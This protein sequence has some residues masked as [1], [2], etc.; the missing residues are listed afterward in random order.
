MRKTKIIG[1]RG[2]AGTHPENTM[3]SFKEAERVGAYGIELDVHLSKDHVL[4]VIHDDKVDRTTNGSGW[5]KDL[6]ASELKEL[7]ASYKFG[8][9]Y[10]FCGIPTLEEVFEWA[11]SNELVINVELKNSLIDYPDIEQKT[12]NFI[13]RYQLKQRVFLSSFNHE[14]MVKANM[15][16]PSIEAAILYME[17]IYEPW[18]YAKKLGLRSIHPYHRTVREDIVKECHQH[19]VSVRPFTI[20]DEAGMKKMISYSCDAIITDYPE[21]ALK[22]KKR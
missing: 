7:D 3:I 16:D 10:G 9:K 21:K 6:K 15:I 13:N 18:E 20:N 2:A 8:D 11:L 4:M 12:I 19:N 14:S 17:K 1:H 22:L 5:V